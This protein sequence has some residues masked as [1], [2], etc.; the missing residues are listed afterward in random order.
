[1]AWSLWDIFGELVQIGLYGNK[2]MIMSNNYLLVFQWWFF[3]QW[4]VANIYRPSAVFYKL[5]YYVQIASW[6]ILLVSLTYT[7][8]VL[9]NTLLLPGDSRWFLAY[10][11]HYHPPL[12]WLQK[13]QLW[14]ILSFS[15]PTPNLF[16]GIVLNIFKVSLQSL[17][18]TSTIKQYYIFSEITWYN[19]SI[20]PIHYVTT[21]RG[22]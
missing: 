5:L 1:M 6:H 11:Q 12:A 7:P 19:I 9:T 3:I 20:L 21:Q 8:P 15:L 18:T 17:T 16:N 13:V 4:E 10:L 2:I 22:Q 14:K